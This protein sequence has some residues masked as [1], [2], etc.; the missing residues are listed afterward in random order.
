MKRI[1]QN[2]LPYWRWILVIMAFLVVQAFCDLSLPQY[3]SDI[4]DVGIQNSGVVHILPEKITSE[5]YEMMQLFMTADE[6]KQFADAYEKDGEK[7]TCVAEKEDLEQLDEDLLLP[8]VMSY[9]VQNSMVDSSENENTESDQEGMGQQMDLASMDKDTLI[10]LFMSGQITDDQ[11]LEM[12]DQ[13]QDKID[14]VGSITMKSMG[15]AYA[16]ACDKNT[17]Y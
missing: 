4:I 9:Q 11:L 10:Q 12:R 7:Y 6:K 17:L 13:L 14:T 5:D 3:T 16:I 15:V 1:F 2:M 8:V